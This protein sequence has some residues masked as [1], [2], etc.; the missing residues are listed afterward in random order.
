MPDTEQACDDTRGDDVTETTDMD[1]QHSSSCVDLRDL[2]ASCTWFE[3]WW[4]DYCDVPCQG[5][6]ERVT[7]QTYTRSDLA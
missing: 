2:G 3:L 4:C 7:R 5:C 1:R 6:G